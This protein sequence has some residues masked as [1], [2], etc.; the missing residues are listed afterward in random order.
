MNG[1][2][3]QA[4]YTIGYGQRQIHEVISL[5]RRY[6]IQFV[7]DVRSVPYSRIRPEFSREA[8]RR[9]FPT[10][11]VQYVFLGHQLGGRPSDPACYRNGKVDYSALSQTPAYRQGIERLRRALQQ[12]LRLCL[13]C[14]EERP[15]DCHRSKLIGQTLAAEGIAVRHIDADGS[16]VDQE[17]VVQRLTGGQQTLFDVSFTSRKRY[18][19]REQRLDE[20]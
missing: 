4:I 17:A 2:V 11:K 9:T 3:H 1:A 19:A 14:T 15:E 12:G 10:A 13:L 6:G 20:V 18:Q 7:V 16:V 5:L 8:L